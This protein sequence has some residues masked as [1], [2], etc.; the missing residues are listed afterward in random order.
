[1]CQGHTRPSMLRQSFSISLPGILH[2]DCHLIL[3]MG[4]LR[5][6]LV[7]VTFLF[8]IQLNLNESLTSKYLVCVCMYYVDVC[9]CVCMYRSEVDIWYL[10]QLLSLLFLQTEVLTEP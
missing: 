4:K 6:K 5:G 2:L 10:S 7:N 8:N 3:E 1:M 9:V